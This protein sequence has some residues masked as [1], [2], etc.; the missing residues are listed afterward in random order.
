M[1]R[2]LAAGKCSFSI[3]ENIQTIDLL[4]VAVPVEWPQWFHDALACLTTAPYLHIRSPQLA[5]KLVKIGG[6]LVGVGSNCRG[7]E[8]CA[9]P[10]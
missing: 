10:R 3:V 6:G 8:L 5:G 4:P 9:D 7:R 2:L 1:S